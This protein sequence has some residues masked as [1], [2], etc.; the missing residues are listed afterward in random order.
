[1]RRFL[2]P[3]ICTNFPH[4][5]DNPSPEISVWKIFFENNYRSSSDTNQL[6]RSPPPPSPFRFVLIF[7][8]GSRIEK[9]LYENIFFWKNQYAVDRFSVVIRKNVVIF[10]GWCIFLVREYYFY[11]AS[12]SHTDFSGIGRPIAK[13]PSKDGIKESKWAFLN[14]DQHTSLSSP[15]IFA[16]SQD[17][18]IIKL[19]ADI[20][21]NYDIAL[22]GNLENYPS[23]LYFVN[24]SSS[25][26][27][28]TLLYYKRAPSLSS[29]ILRRRVC[30]K[31][32]ITMNYSRCNRVIFVLKIPKIIITV[33]YLS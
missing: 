29:F 15:R 4:R 14:I 2:G 24:N 19:V 33:E 1:V 10:L 21:T 20:F 11:I 17:S 9:F 3:S 31:F 16:T 27:A 23:S 26:L 5:I 6:F 8:G 28:I 18:P 22:W 7:I 30:I 13:N 25:S 12:G 32:S